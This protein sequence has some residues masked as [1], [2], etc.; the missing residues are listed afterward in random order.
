MT[1]VF[2]ERDLQITM[3]NVKE[4]RRFDGPD[5]GLSHCMNAVDFVV[6]LDDRFLFIEF[7]DPQHPGA[8]TESR[9]NFI[10]RL[11]SGSLDEELKHKYRD[12]FLY[13]WAA[14]RIGKPIY[15]MV[16]IAHDALTSADRVLDRRTSELKRKLPAGLPSKWIHTIVEDCAVFNLASWNQRFQDFQ[17]TRVS[18]LQ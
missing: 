8:T 15:Y 6:E 12:S 16:L 9:E 18:S 1:W 17:V 14:G 4:A 3:S 11:L 13:L 2:E 10:G 7:K 5:H